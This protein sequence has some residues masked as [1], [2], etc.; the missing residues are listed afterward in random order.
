MSRLS[1]RN[2]FVA[3][4]VAAGLAM[5]AGWWWFDQPAT[6]RVPA[7]FVDTP[8]YETKIASFR[9]TPED[10]RIIAEKHLKAIQPQ[11]QPYDRLG[12]HSVVL[13]DDYVF[14]S[15]QEKLG[16]ALDGIYVDGHT[17]HVGIK[18]TIEVARP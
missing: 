10:A 6:E 12:I 18:R 14:S 15:Y 2:L 4:V 13:G 1:A 8:T 5:V 16:V 17:G 7:Y 11:P 3:L 9:Y